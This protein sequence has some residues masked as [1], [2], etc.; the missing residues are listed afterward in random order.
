[1]Y[2]FFLILGLGIIVLV[3]LFGLIY[4]KLVG[5]LILFLL[6][7]VKNFKYIIWKMFLVI[8][9]SVVLK[10]ILVILKIRKR[11]ECCYIF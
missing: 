4:M 8:F 10:N 3:E 7:Y 2:G 6:V 11:I 9:Y 5:K 1:M